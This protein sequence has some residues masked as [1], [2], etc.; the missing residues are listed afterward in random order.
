LA[1]TY[2]RGAY[3]STNGDLGVPETSI[4]ERPAMIYPN[5]SQGNMLAMRFDGAKYKNVSAT[6]FD[7]SGRKL[8][9]IENVTSDTQYNIQ[10][11]RGNY[12]VVL[13]SNGERFYSSFLL[14][15]GRERD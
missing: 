15:Q 12:M 14:V 10:L 7:A 4:E 5:P 13:E 1:S 3:T 8:K 11:K 6:I 2:G 9:T